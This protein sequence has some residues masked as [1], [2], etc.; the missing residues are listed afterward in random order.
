MTAPVCITFFNIADGIE[1]QEESHLIT[2]RSVTV[3][4]KSPIRFFLSLRVVPHFIILGGVTQYQTNCL[5]PLLTYKVAL[6]ELPKLLQKY[7]EWITS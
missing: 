2:A 7:K 5:C 3:K 6:P 1:K 4:L